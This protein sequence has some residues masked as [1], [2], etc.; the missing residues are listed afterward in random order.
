MSQDTPPVVYLPLPMP[1]TRKRTAQPSARAIASAVAAAMKPRYRR[2]V[3]SGRG[4]YTRRAPMRRVNRRYLHGRGGFF[5]DLWDTVKTVGR[6]AWGAVRKPLGNFLGN[7]IAGLGDYTIHKNSILEEGQDPPHMANS[8]HYNIFRH[9]EYLGD[10]S[11]PGAAFNIQ[12]FPINP[13]MVQTFPWFSSLAQNY[14]AYKPRGIVF[15]YKAMSAD[16]LNSTNTALGSVLLATQYNVLQPA[17]L[18]QS[19]MLNYD[20]S[21]ATVPSRSC[22]HPVE[23]DPNSLPFR[24]YTVRHGAIPTGQ[25]A[26]IFDMAT[27]YIATYGQQAASVI[28]QLWVT[29]EFEMLTPTMEG[30]AGETILS[31]SWMGKTGISTSAYFGTTV[32]PCANNSLGLTLGKT[33]VT[34]PPWITQ[35]IYTLTH[36]VQGDLTAVTWPTISYTTNCK[37]VGGTVAGPAPATTASTAVFQTAAFRITGPSAVLTWSSGTLPANATAAYLWVTQVDSD[38]DYAYAGTAVT[39]A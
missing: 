3:L 19:Q 5:S 26:R 1:V 34:F 16:A 17:F 33:T 22:L 18:N 8:K 27:F 7:Q 39:P 11:T 36:V 37:V 13:G 4:A 21:T 9:R 10:I 29:F 32:T 23:C 6:G 24:E 2:K 20:K 28:G 35:G 25:D 30:G 38:M 31:D 12:A 15:E 14:S